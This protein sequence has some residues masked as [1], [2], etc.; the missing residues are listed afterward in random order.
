M[1]KGADKSIGIGSERDPSIPDGRSGQTSFI[2]CL[3]NNKTLLPL[4]FLEVRI[5]SD[6]KSSKF[7]S[8]DSARV[9][10]TFWGSA[11]SKGF[12][13]EDTEGTKTAPVKSRY[14]R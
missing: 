8:A 13:T 14:A 1:V 6:F 9:R 4:I 2:A 7:G 12:N 3:V 10:A 5:I 11:D